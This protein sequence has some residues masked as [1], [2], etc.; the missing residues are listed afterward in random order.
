[1]AVCEL[2]VWPDQMHVFHA[3]PALVP[4]ART[5]YRAAARFV[6]DILDATTRTERTS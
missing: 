4:E 6:T 3:M 2:A 1:M 5:A